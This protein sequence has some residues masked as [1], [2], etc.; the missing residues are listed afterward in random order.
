MKRVALK[1][2]EVKH[3]LKSFLHEYPLAQEI[4][5]IRSRIEY[6]KI[7]DARLLYVGGRPLVLEIEDSRIPTL[8]FQEVLDSLS[9]VIVDMGAVPHICRG[10]DVMAPG[11]RGIEGTFGEGTVIRVLDERYRKVLSIGISLLSSAE[12]ADMKQG[13]VVKNLHYVGDDIWRVL[14][15][16]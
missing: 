2:K 12:M 7:G 11:V 15:I 14:N 1:A 16:I 4:F 8:I 5:K 6:T 10:A 13:R 9:G 3:L